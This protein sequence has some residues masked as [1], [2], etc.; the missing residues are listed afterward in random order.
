MR[1]DISEVNTVNNCVNISLSI[2]LYQICTVYLFLLT[3]NIV[4]QIRE[5][6]VMN[7]G[8]FTYDYHAFLLSHIMIRAALFFIT[9]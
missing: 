3:E 1:L 8:Q 4:L 7:K 6:V 5:H 2:R 9:K